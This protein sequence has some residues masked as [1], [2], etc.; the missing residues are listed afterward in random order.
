MLA[1]LPS[2]RAPDAVT[3]ANTVELLRASVEQRA[4]GHAAVE[5][6]L[7]VDGMEDAEL[8]VILHRQARA[9]LYLDR[10]VTPILVYTEDQL[11]ETYRTTS[12]PYRARRFEDCR[13]DLA[14]WLLVERFRSAE[15][16][17]L[18]TARSRVT[19]SY[20]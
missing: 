5:H 13:E 9:A 15:Q 20:M 1:S 10:A 8:G 19:V 6:A 12:H 18:Q 2:E 16:G 7:K 17:Y 3:I 11:R 14:R 4:G